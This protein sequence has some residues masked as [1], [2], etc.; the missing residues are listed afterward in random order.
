VRTAP[1]A[2]DLVQA[3]LAVSGDW[4]TEPLDA[5]T[6]TTVINCWQALA[7]R[8]QSGEIAADALAELRWQH[9]IPNGHH[10]LTAPDEMLLA[11]RPDLVEQFTE[12]TPYFLPTDVT[13]L[14]A[15]IAAGVR[16][17]SQ[18]MM[19]VVVDGHEA[20]ADT[21]VKERIAARYPLL[22]RLLR[23][24]TA[25]GHTVQAD[26]LQKLK[27]MA[28]PNLRIQA[29]LRLDAQIKMA[30]GESVSAK[31]IHGVLYLD[32]EKQPIPWTAV[33]RELAKAVAPERNVV[34][35]ALGIKEV[36]A[37]EST[38]AATAVLDELGYP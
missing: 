36:L 5:A 13:W 34:G 32:S 12:W 20:V 6:H 11:D 17:L 3:L 8:V 38:G 2:A 28:L 14:P 19:V 29:Q 18:A 21:A 16:P 30:E 26:V 4:G 22:E 35:L 23:A 37:A 10:M 7:E 1:A 25:A 15:A 9:V 24:E 27:V 31:W 33:A